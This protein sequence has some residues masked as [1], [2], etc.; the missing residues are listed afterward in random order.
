LSL[1]QIPASQHKEALK[2][3][4]QFVLRSE[5]GE[6]RWQ[7]QDSVVEMA[8]FLGPQHKLSLEEILGIMK[9]K[10]LVDF[11]RPMLKTILSRL[12]ENGRVTYDGRYALSSHRRR[13]I[14]NQTQERISAVK[15]LTDQL[16]SKTEECLRTKLS[17][18][19]RELIE[20]CFFRFLSS[21]FVERTSIFAKLI[22]G[23][24]AP[25]TT[26]SGPTVILDGSLQLIADKELREAAS[27]AILDIFRNPTE[28]LVDF[29]LHLNENLIC[30]QVLNLDPECQRLEREAF[31]RINLLL[32]TNVLIDLLCPSSRRNRLSKELLNFTNH[33]GAHLLVTKRTVEEFLDVLENANTSFRNL[34]IPPRFLAVLDDEFIVSYCKEKEAN[35]HVKWEGYYLRMRRAASLLKN[36]WGVGLYEDDWKEILERKGFHDIADQVSKCYKKLT[37][38]PKTMKAAEHDAYHLILIRELRRESITTI[39]G[40]S[41]WFLTYD[42]T[43]PCAE[44]LVTEKLAYKDRT[45]S[46]MLVDIWLQMIE[47]FLGRDVRERQVAQVFSELLKSQFSQIPFRIG[48]SKMAEL[49]GEWL[50]YDWLEPEDIKKILG[51]KFVSDYLSKLAKLRQEGENT[52]TLTEEF[53]QKLEERVES[54]ASRRIHQLT[55]RVTD[56]EEQV[57]QKE[58]REKLLK[59]QLSLKEEEFRRGWRSKVGTLGCLVILVNMFLI[60]VGAIRDAVTIGVIFLFGLLFTLLAVAPEQIV[61]RIEAF[62]GWGKK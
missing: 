27:A 41:H 39:L 22:A 32:D 30:I 5:T 25:D 1:V 2:R 18:E 57:R 11:P 36:N 3:I 59:T 54:L 43:L 40:P 23:H 4:S 28:P 62:F 24:E 20:E 55:G 34:N 58:D 15:S 38:L 29:F 53:K 61:A 16:M 42:R 17:A 37:N 46:T 21:L 8:I 49:Q 45:V 19:N 9:D 35:P 31:S 52:G 14:Q 12:T 13:D 51:E 50:N 6:I 48:P 56:L 44:P 7:I 60:I 26:P 33:V 10:I 47:P